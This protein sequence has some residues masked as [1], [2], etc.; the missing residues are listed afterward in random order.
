MGIRHQLFQFC[1]FKHLNMIAPFQKVPRHLEQPAGL[2]TDDQ[3]SNFRVFAL[4]A[5]MEQE[6]PGS[7]RCLSGEAPDDVVSFLLKNAE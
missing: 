5:V 7:R 2:E 1:G 3:F 6:L 4:L